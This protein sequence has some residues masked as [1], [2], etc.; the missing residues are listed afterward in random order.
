MPLGSCETNIKQLKLLLAEK[1]SS[2]TL[3]TSQ[4]PQSKILKIFLMTLVA[5]FC[6]CVVLLVLSDQSYGQLSLSF[7]GKE[8]F[9]YMDYWRKQQSTQLHDVCFIKTRKTASTTLSSIL[10][11][12]ALTH[13]LSLALMKTNTRSGHFNIIPIREDSPRELFLPP[14][15]VKPGDWTNYKYNMMTVH[16][17][18]NRSAFETFMNP[19]TKYISILR[20]T[21]SH[22]ESDFV[23]Y[24]IPA[25]VKSIKEN[26][27]IEET[28]QEYFRDPEYYWEQTMNDYGEKFKFFTRNVQAFDLGL[29]HI[30]HN[31]TDVLN[32]FI[33]KL[34]DEIDLMLITEY[35]DESLL[36]LKKL[37]RWD[38][39]DVM[40][41]AR[42]MRPQNTTR[43]TL[44]LDLCKKIKEWNSADDML[45]Q[46]FNKTFWSRVKEYGKDWQRDLDK[47][48]RQLRT[49]QS[50]CSVT[51]ATS[52]KRSHERVVYKIHNSSSTLCKLLTVNNNNITQ[53]IMQKQSP[54]YY[55]LNSE[56]LDSQRQK[57]CGFEYRA[58]CG[59]T[60][61]GEKG[62]EWTF[63]QELQIED[64]TTNS[65]YG[66]I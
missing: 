45:Y 44:T 25:V 10:N 56:G 8:T 62:Y 13:N 65:T 42:N 59:F 54:G 14:L 33:R 39:N 15:G 58:N 46:T 24:R 22:F 21:C 57:I 23:Y 38:W 43:A 28:L 51:T 20:E 7:L 34:K 6:Y 4:M 53:E 17:R 66:S 31:D 1:K 5:G 2:D 27:N 12:Y 61:A 37:L 55:V 52:V 19:G 36:L 50:N 47:M 63:D 9:T 48:K 35:F 30:Y 3:M 64:V 40:Y 29:D 32:T 18:Y 26:I 49:I 60:F 11:R 41:I 16:V